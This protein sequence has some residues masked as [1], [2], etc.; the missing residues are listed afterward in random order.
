MI[1][2]IQSPRFKLLASSQH[3]PSPFHF[4]PILPSFKKKGVGSALGNICCLISA[5]A[6]RRDVFHGALEILQAPRACLLKWGRWEVASHLRFPI[7]ALTDPSQCRTP[8]YR[9]EHDDKSQRLSPLSVTF[10][11]F[12]K[13]ALELPGATC[14]V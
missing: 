2:R 7:A 9:E 1:F 4:H 12:G 14:V 13:T 11:I 5:F 10:C 3:S 6:L 8:F